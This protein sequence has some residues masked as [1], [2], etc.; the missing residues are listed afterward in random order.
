MTHLLTEMKSLKTETVA[1]SL[2]KDCILL[3]VKTSMWWGHLNSDY[4]R[5]YLCVSRRLI[6]PG[7]AN[8]VC[9]LLDRRGGNGKS[10]NNGVDVIRWVA[11]V[12]SVGNEAT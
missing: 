2:Y 3:S 5:L 1:V 7:K 4:H 6:R 10:D 8:Y 9:A 11:D 12:N